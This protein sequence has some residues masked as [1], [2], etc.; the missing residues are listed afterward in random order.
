MSPKEHERFKSYYKEFKQLEQKGCRFFYPWEESIGARKMARTM[1]RDESATYMR[2]QVYD[3]K[4]RLI[5]IHFN[6]I[7][8]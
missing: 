8:L 5:G 7:E 2:D 1:A 6:R 4:G 3:R